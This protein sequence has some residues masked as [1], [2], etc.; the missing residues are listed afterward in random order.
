MLICQHGEHDPPGSGRMPKHFWITKLGRTDIQQ[1]VAR[2]FGPGAPAVCAV[3]QVLGLFFRCVSS[4]NGDHWRLTIAAQA[5]G[6]APV[7]HRAA[8]E[9]HNPIFFKEGNWKM[10]PLYQVMTDGVPPAHVP[11]TLAKWV[12]LV[13]QVILAGIKDQSIWVVHEISWRGEVNLGTW[14]HDR[15]STSWV[16][17][18]W[19]NLNASRFQ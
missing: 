14:D 6:V 9:D 13:E 12:V 11:P 4:V 17:P 16:S 3:C 5:T 1:R 10:L 7:H 15:K 2:I 18:R 8:G 19:I